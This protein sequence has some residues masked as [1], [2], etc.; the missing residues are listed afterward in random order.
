MNVRK[1]KFIVLAVLVLAL[2][3][4]S[5]FEKMDQLAYEKVSET[6]L[7]TAGILAAL[8]VIDASV[9]ILQ[10]FE[11]GA[12]IASIKL[13]QA[14]DP[15]NTMV[16]NLSAVVAW[17]TGS[18][19]LQQVLLQ[20]VANDFFRFVFLTLGLITFLTLS[21]AFS[22]KCQSFINGYGI[23]E[24]SMNLICTRV[25]K[26]F[27]T[28]AVVRFIVPTFVLCS[29]L[30]S[31][32]L[33]QSDLNKHK[34]Y[35]TEFSNE[36]QI[37]TV[38]SIPSPSELAEK[39]QGLKTELSTLQSQLLN[40]QLDLDVTEENL[41]VLDKKE[42]SRKSVPSNDDSKA[43]SS[44]V[45]ELI[46]Q[47]QDV[48][49]KIKIAKQRIA[50]LERDLECIARQKEGKN[51][52]SLMERLDP[53]ESISRAKDVG[54]RILGIANK[55]RQ[56]SAD[57]SIP[58]QSELAERE[59]ILNAELIG[60]QSELSNYQLELDAVDNKF[61]DLNKKLKAHRQEVQQKIEIAEERTADLEDDLECIERQ[62][63]GENCTSMWDRV[64]QSKGFLA[65][66]LAS[67]KASAKDVIDSLITLLI[68]V[69]VKNIL[70]PLVFAYLAM[71]FSLPI[72][73]KVMDVKVE[74]QKTAKGI[75]A[76]TQR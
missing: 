25:V 1:T 22:H 66:K 61:S 20:I 9:S 45:D 44:D 76:E 36:S 54:T 74:F 68:I 17:A 55:D 51:C 75:V 64:S 43:Y 14:L 30:F 62:T 35:T 63:E 12:G 2:S 5:F 33:V 46:V 52:E 37:D 48:Q 47:R 6:A 67:V 29:F 27:F 15:L 23:S 34:S 57:S 39:E 58:T 59:Q 53:R 32:A 8:T 69:L 4:L 21:V 7:E 10:S 31:E 11:V 19:F 49:R 72:L 26:L 41:N 38:A 71:K 40:H 24:E 16:E 3:A 50:E 65:Q 73:K 70:F 13:G 56:V 42:L 18:L 60:S 28:V